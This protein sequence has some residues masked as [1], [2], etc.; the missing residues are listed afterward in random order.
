M[1]KN[2]N[3]ELEEYGFESESE[4]N[5]TVEVRYFE[6]PIKNLPET[7]EIDNYIIT[8]KQVYKNPN[9]TTSLVWS[10]DTDSKVSHQEQWE[11]HTKSIDINNVNT[12]P[13]ILEKNK[14]YRLMTMGPAYFDN[15]EIAK[16][17]NVTDKDLL[18]RCGF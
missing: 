2:Y 3:I 9:S 1:K 11:Q 4:S 15:P 16:A 6:K 5:I 10:P 7:I 13:E 14:E 17:Y 12:D 8:L 18:E